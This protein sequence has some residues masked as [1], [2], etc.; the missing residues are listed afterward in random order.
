MNTDKKT[1]VG[2]ASGSRYIGVLCPL[3]LR[4]TTAARTE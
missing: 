1:M 2:R 4:I 3:L